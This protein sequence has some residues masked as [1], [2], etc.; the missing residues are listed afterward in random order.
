MS[1]LIAIVSNDTEE[2]QEMLSTLAR[3]DLPASPLDS[4]PAVLTL[5]TEQNVQVIVL[6]LDTVPADNLF[7][8]QLK[9][10]K[11]SL[12]IVAFSS[13]PFHPELK[14]AFKEHIQA[15]LRK[16][17]DPD[18]FIFWIRSILRIQPEETVGPE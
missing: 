17:L 3:Q 9:T 10:I 16:P 1:G 13:R 8:K 12:A 7:F 5:V 11:P 15:C 18:E 2:R 6:D 14:I 4:L